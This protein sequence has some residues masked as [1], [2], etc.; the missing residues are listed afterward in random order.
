M[1]TLTHIGRVPWTNSQMRERLE[2]FTAVYANRPIQDNE[3]G[4]RSPHMFLA[5]FL[6]RF[7]RPQVVIESGVWLGQG[8]W[9]IES[10][11][12]D[13]QLHCIDPNLDQI[14]YRSTRAVYHN[15][16]FN[17]ID[18]RA[19]PREET[20]L[21]FDDHQNALSRVQ[22]AQRRGFKHLVFEDNYPQGHGDCYSLKMA[23]ERAGFQPAHPRSSGIK[24]KFR[25]LLG[26]G[27]EPSEAVP[28][29]EADAQYLEENLELYCE[30]PPI[31]LAPQTRWG[32]PWD[33]DRYPT[34]DPLL[35]SVNHTYQEVYLDEAVH[36]TWMCYARLK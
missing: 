21:F 8:T 33:D 1:N 35:T 14:Q 30:L 23:F 4:M 32:T 36:Y 19:L 6:F 3:G 2:E 16:D 15:Q 7:L 29:N 22:S 34:P 5:W 9:L 10:A 28:P 25:A 11:C 20:L 27:G 18:W 17:T 26:M 24:Q 12:P 13:A 31:F